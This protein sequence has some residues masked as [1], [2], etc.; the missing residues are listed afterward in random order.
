[1]A[2]T[3]YTPIEYKANDYSGLRSLHGITDEQIEVHLKLY[4]G[5]VT[6]TNALL[7]KTAKMANEGQHADSSYQELKRRAGWEWNGMRLHE[8]YFDNLGGSGQAGAGPCKCRIHD[9]G[10]SERRDFPHTRAQF[11]RVGM[12]LGALFSHA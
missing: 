1:M 3:T 12:H 6:R 9:D 2:N 10:R 7:A 5:Y 8:F 4:N 11:R